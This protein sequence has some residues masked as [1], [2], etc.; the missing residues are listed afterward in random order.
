M[1]LS[2]KFR[3][4]LSIYGL[5][6]LGVFLLLLIPFI[7]PLPG[8]G[9]I[10]LLIAGL[11]LLSI[12]NTWAQKLQNYIKKK[13]LGLSDL[14]FPNTLKAQILWDLGI[15]WGLVSS[16]S[17]LV[18]YDVGGIVILVISTIMTTLG[19]CWLRNRYR[20]QRFLVYLKINKRVEQS[21]N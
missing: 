7:G 11:K 5:N 12:N 19:A 8:P 21:K 4:K 1:S 10:P 20:W 6:A 13:G 9:G 17:L 18:I 2:I 14:V 16:I 3:R 15:L